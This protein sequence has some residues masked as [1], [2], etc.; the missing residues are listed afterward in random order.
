MRGN[1]QRKENASINR[2]DAHISKLVRKLWSPE[3]RWEMVN[4]GERVE[5]KK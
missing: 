5:E 2:S 1:K 3:K 4:E